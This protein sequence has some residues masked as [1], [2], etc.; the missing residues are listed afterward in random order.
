M[1]P[2][3]NCALGRLKLVPELNNL[4][5]SAKTET[6]CAIHWPHPN[7]KDALGKKKKYRLNELSVL[8]EPPSQCLKWKNVVVCR[9]TLPS[10]PC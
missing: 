9:N 4:G 1:G 2:S 8:L 6:F 7:L 10:T 5:L 3:L